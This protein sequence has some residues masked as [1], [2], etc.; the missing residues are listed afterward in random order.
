MSEK[1]KTTKRIPDVRSA[2]RRGVPTDGHK[3]T[4]ARDKEIK[5]LWK[6]ILVTLKSINEKHSMEVES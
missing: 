3:H 4:D 6:S 2:R 1:G 5:E